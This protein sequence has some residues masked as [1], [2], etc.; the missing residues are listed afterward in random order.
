MATAFLIACAFGA[1]ACWIIVLIKLF[2]NG[3]TMQGVLGLFCG[4]VAYIYGWA[5]ADDLD[6]RPVMYAWTRCVIVYVV[7]L[8][9]VA[10]DG[11]PAQ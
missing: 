6:V 9:R 7:M 2:T 4:V 11:V 3:Y 1:V 5:K 10:S 8:F